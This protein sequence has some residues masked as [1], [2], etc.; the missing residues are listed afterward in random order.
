M[1]LLGVGCDSVEDSSVQLPEI[2]ST[3]I[4]PSNQRSTGDPDEG[5]AYL[6]EGGYVGRGIP[7]EIFQA[8]G[9]GSELGNVLDRSGDGATLP[10][11]FN[12]VTAPN[13][14]RMAAPNCLSC[15]AQT[16]N[17][18]YIV[19]LGNSV[20]DF[21]NDSSTLI[22]LLDQFIRS[23][24]GEGSPEWEAYVP[25]RRA[26]LAIGPNIRTRVQG[27]NPADRL[28]FVLSA[29]RDPVTLAW[30]DTPL[31]PLPEPAGYV[32]PTDVPAWWLLKKKNAM[33]YTG[34]GRGDFARISMASSLLTLQDTTE[35]RQIDERFADVVAYIR[36]IEPPPYPE[37]IDN[38]LA[39]RG[40][41]VFEA[42][43]SVCH[44]TYGADPTYPNLLIDLETIGTD[45][46]LA[47]SYI[48][49]KR[50][51]DLYNESWFASP[52]HAARLETEPGYVAPPLDGIW[53]TAP[54]FHNGSVPTLA[55]VLDSRNRPTYWKR[56]FDTSAY[57]YEKVGWV[58]TRETAGGPRTIYDTTLPAHGNQGHVFGDVLDTDDRRAVIEYLKTL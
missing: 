20:T 42:N 27:L 15:H 28:T 47:Q 8:A 43:C 40:R 36:S 7:L 44:G 54:Y 21:T 41:T 55:D 30:S 3:F 23:R 31:Y 57:D 53:A 56:T 16:I 38:T 12:A 26:T 14:V 11:E 58:Y 25:F 37:V 17:G 2:K 45:A 39:E 33:F 6:V 29:H 51:L 1:M 24:Y 32:V 10:P 49:N 4:A 35:A 48:L 46:E 50:F 22:P 5:Y 9:V 13:G 19:G 52:P 34:L 18:D